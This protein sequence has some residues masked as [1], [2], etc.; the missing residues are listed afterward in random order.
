MDCSLCYD[1]V[2]H[3]LPV[4][5]HDGLFERPLERGK[6][7]LYG[8]ALAAAALLHSRRLGDIARKMAPRVLAEAEESARGGGGGTT[9]GVLQSIFPTAMPIDHASAILP[10]K[11]QR[12]DGYWAGHHKARERVDRH[13]HVPLPAA[14][15]NEHP[16]GPALVSQDGFK[17]LVKNPSAAEYRLIQLLTVCCFGVCYI[18][19]LSPRQ[20]FQ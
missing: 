14:H 1:L 9:F 10:L 16:V 4:S 11:R 12:Q 2:D 18:S 15:H 17:P 13:V 3:V 8:L 7:P 5:G 6:R 20:F 19:P